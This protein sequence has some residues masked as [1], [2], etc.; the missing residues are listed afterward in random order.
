MLMGLEGLN[1]LE[2]YQLNVEDIDFRVCEISVR[3][4]GKTD[5]MKSADN[6]DACLGA[7]SRLSY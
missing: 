2:V 3:R 7:E 4:K 5:I 6:P 1:P